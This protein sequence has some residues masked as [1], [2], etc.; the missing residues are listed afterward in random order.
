MKGLIA[1]GEFRAAGLDPA[2][3]VWLEMESGDI[4]I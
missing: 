4:A 2:D 1:D 3:S